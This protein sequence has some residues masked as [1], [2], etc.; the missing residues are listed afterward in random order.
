AVAP[1]NHC[2]LLV[3]E[4]ETAVQRL[5]GRVVPGCDVAEIDVRQHRAR[6]LQL[7]VSDAW[8]VVDRDRRRQRPRDLNA[9]VTSVALGLRQPSIARPEIDGARGELGD[10]ATRSD[11]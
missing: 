7:V 3:G 2:D 4:V 6:E 1:V 10:A 5:D 11:G 8:D 9:A